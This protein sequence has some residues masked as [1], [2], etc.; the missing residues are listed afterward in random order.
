MYHHL[1]GDAAP[2]R[3]ALD[4]DP[5]DA[6]VH[7]RV[8]VSL[9]EPRAA[10][11][12]GV[13]RSTRRAIAKVARCSVQHQRLVGAA[14]ICGGCRGVRSRQRVQR[15]AAWLP[16]PVVHGPVLQSTV[17]VNSGQAV[18]PPVA[19]WMTVRSRTLVP[20]PQVSEQAPKSP[21]SDTMQSCLAAVE[22]RNEIQSVCVRVRAN[23]FIANTMGHHREGRQL[24]THPMYLLQ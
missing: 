12:V 13:V 19:A 3:V 8:C 21:H 6:K 2:G 24:R 7:L 20:P 11:V 18:P 5:V 14:S 15:H 17:F 10:R 4:I 22:M 9:D 16:L 1:V 23:L